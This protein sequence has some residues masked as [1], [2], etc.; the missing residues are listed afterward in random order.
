M[1]IQ[2]ADT[3]AAPDAGVASVQQIAPDAPPTPLESVMLQQ[4]KLYVVVAVV[5]I[6]WLGVLALLYANDRRLARLEQALGPQE[7]P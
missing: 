7:N 2:S 6:I 3:L 1:T 5:L 4:D